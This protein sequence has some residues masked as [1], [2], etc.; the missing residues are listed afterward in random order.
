ML[1]L[2]LFGAFGFFSLGVVIAHGAVDYLDRQK[3]ARAHARRLARIEATRKRYLG[4]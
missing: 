1:A 3:F 4:E 2:F